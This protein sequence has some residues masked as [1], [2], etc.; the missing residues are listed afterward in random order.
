MSA[1]HFLDARAANLP[2]Q[3][4]SNAEILHQKDEV[5]E[6][7]QELLGNN[8]IDI[9]PS[10]RPWAAPIIIVHKPNTCIRLCVDYRRLNSITTKDAQRETGLLF[11]ELDVAFLLQSTLSVCVLV[12]NVQNS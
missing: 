7:V 11:G 4:T 2:L 9:G 1:I 12:P 5:Q 8:I 10:S 3:S 6:H